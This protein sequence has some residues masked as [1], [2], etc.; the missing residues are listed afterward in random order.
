MN[1]REKEI[2]TDTDIMKQLILSRLFRKSKL[3]EDINFEEEK[4]E[5]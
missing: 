2:L 1:D 5:M 3:L 4:N